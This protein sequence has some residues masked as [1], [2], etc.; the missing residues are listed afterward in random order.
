MFRKHL[1]NNAG[2][3]LGEILVCLALVSFV[4]AVGVPVVAAITGEMDGSMSRVMGSFKN[5]L[6][7]GY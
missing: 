7:S 3:G 6:N 5:M 2:F 4:V 1:N